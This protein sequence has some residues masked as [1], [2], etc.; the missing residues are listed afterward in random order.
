MGATFD[1][2]L[3]LNSKSSSIKVDFEEG[4]QKRLVVIRMYLQL[5][6]AKTVID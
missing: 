2:W 1:L 5:I 4:L 6:L 3:F